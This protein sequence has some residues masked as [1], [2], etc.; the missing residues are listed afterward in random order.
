[1]DTKV[2][3]YLIKPI[4]AF[5]LSGISLSLFGMDVHILPFDYMRDAE[6]AK[7]IGLEGRLGGISD[8]YHQLTSDSKVARVGNQTV[9]FID[10]EMYE[11]DLLGEAY[12]YIAYL[13]VAQC[14]RGR[15][16]GRKLLMCA[17][18]DIQ[19]HGYRCVKLNVMRD[20]VPA[21]RLYESEGF[22]FAESADESNSTVTM[23]YEVHPQELH[24]HDALSWL[25]YFAYQGV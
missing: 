6:A 3:C 9:G 13:G 12:A 21:I 25:Y 16:I 14:M 19:A 2:S 5:V 18:R 11:K 20:N 22:V 1:M 17:L 7:R 4:V 15:G 8:A 23:V 24:S 10:Y